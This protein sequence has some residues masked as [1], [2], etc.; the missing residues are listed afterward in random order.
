MVHNAAQRAVRPFFSFSC[1]ISTLIDMVDYRTPSI[2]EELS[3]EGNMCGINGVVLGGE[4]LPLFCKVEI[5]E[6][7]LNTCCVS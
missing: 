4:L 1:I 3:F 6:L 7:L 2:N 5:S